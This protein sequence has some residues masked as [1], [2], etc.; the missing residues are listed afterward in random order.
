MSGIPISAVS[1]GPVLCCTVLHFTVNLS[2]W[3]TP[4]HV[5]CLFRSLS[6]SH[7]SVQSGEQCLW[8]VWKEDCWRWNLQVP[9]THTHTHCAMNCLHAILLTQLIRLKQCSKC[10]GKSASLP[11]S[12]NTAGCMLSHAN[13]SQCQIYAGW[14]CIHSPGISDCAVLPNDFL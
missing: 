12:C 11:L 2:I 6:L 3:I 13:D 5:S 10:K 4:P 7:I 9:H 1:I 14:K 8:P